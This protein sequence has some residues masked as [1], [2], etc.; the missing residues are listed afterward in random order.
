MQV[1]TPLEVDRASPS[2]T[3]FWAS[4]LLLAS[5]SVSVQA[6]SYGRLLASIIGWFYM[7]G[8]NH[9]YGACATTFRILELPINIGITDSL[10]YHCISEYQQNVL[11]FEIS[12]GVIRALDYKLSS[13]HWGVWGREL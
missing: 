11:Q 3:S 5:E 12:I 4:S 10:Q 1:P 8:V 2:V 7:G 6:S 9:A 13:S